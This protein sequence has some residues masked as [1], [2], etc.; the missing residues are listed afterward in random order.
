MPILLMGNRPPEIAS[1]KLD[2]SES[3]SHM[4]ESSVTQ[5]P[6]ED[7]SPMTDHIQNKPDTLVM[8]GF[9]TNSPVQLLVLSGPRNGETAFEALEK[10]HRDR[11]PVKVFT[12]LKEYTDMALVSFVVPKSPETGD[13]FRFTATFQKIQKVHS[14]F[15]QVIDLR[16]DSIG[17]ADMASSK[18]DLGKQAT[19]TPKAGVQSLL[20]RLA[21][22]QVGT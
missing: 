11:E 20:R 22:P 6:V 17:T 21:F 2:L 16:V 14:L 10:I 15:V 9:V 7:G 19:S 4:F 8:E 18:G 12:T 13:A 3:E 1:I 5:Y